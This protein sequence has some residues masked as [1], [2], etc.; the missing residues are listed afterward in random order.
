MSD[1][2]CLYTPPFDWIESYRQVIDLAVDNGMSVIEGFNCFEFSQPDLAKAR[3][4][5]AYADRKGVRFACLSVY[6][7]VSGE[8]AEQEVQK[9]KAY[10]QI[11]SILG[12][13]YLHHTIAPEHNTPDHGSLETFYQKGLHSVREIYDYAETQGVKTVYE[14]QGYVFN[15]VDGFGRFLRDVNRDVAVVMDLGNIFQTDES[16]EAFIETFAS[17]IV[18]THIKDVSYSREYREGWYQTLHGN[19]FTCNR[20]GDGIIDIPHCIRLLE[21]AGYTGCYGLEFSAGPGGDASMKAYIEQAKAW[22]K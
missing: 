8:N 2:I 12:S 16:P 17:K 13:P 14:D 10:A 6:A 7:D 21:A 19:Y 15:G 5:R 4:I 3:E 20:P 18:H 11:A 1:R 22:L 9:V